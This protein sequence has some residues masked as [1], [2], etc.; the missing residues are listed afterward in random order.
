MKREKGQINLEDFSSAQLLIN[1]QNSTWR[2]KIEEK[3]QRRD[4]S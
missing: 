3:M 4:A 1:A 2:E